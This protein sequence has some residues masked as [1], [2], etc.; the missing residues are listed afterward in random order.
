MVEK[1]CYG[2]VNLIIF[3][4]VIP[5]AR[6]YAAHNCGAVPLLRDVQAAAGGDEVRGI[7]SRRE[8]VCCCRPRRHLLLGP[9]ARCRR[10]TGHFGLGISFGLFGDLAQRIVPANVTPK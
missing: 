9:S 7:R 2:P 4:I 10:R 3:G 1:L 5:S 8:W 6:S